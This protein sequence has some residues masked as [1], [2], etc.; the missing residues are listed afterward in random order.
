MCLCWSVEGDD[1][2]FVA[3]N[4]AYRPNVIYLYIY[5]LCASPRSL[6]VFRP[7][8]PIYCNT[9]LDGTI[10]MGEVAIYH[11]IPNIYILH[12]RIIVEDPW[13]KYQS[14]TESGVVT[15]LLFSPVRMDVSTE[16][17]RS[18]LR[19]FWAERTLI[20]YF[21]LRPARCCALPPWI[22]HFINADRSKGILWYKHLYICSILTFERSD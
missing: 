10:Y 6:L 20:C 8:S 13:A 18:W 22:L 16:M 17:A 19:L 4:L 21:L 1:W 2:M 7:L 14:G 5:I 15:H 9:V 12:H 3:Y 11:N